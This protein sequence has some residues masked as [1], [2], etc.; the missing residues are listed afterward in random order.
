MKEFSSKIVLITGAGSGIGR[1]TAHLFGSM[2]ASVVVADCDDQ[3]AKKV[4]G[5]I[6]G[7][8]GIATSI[9]CDVTV[10][11][12]VRNLLRATVDR[13]E[14]LDYAVNNAG[15]TGPI[16]PLVDFDVS[17]ARKIIDINLMGVLLC[18]QEELKVMM[19]SGTGAVVNTC[20]IWGRAAAANFAAYCASK[21]AVAGLTKAVALEMAQTGIRV[22]AVC[23]GFTET[24]MVTE[25]GLK[26]KRGTPEHKAAGDAHP[27]GRMAQPEEIA[28]GIVWLCSERS[29]FV[30]G[31]C[32]AID[33]GFLA[34]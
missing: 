2:G 27:M 16:A 3:H 12:D 26:L 29:S 11:T 1:A 20:S 23:P 31:E 9:A 14:R 33:G 17:A 7:S 19:P 24:P 28:Q 22:N 13:Y 5:E 15:I 8:G 30:T 34:R 25:R 10:D 21:H 32:L 18:M 6:T 4:A